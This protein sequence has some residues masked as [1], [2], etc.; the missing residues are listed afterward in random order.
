MNKAKRSP[1]ARVAQ[2]AA[3]AR[4]LREWW[5]SKHRAVT[6]ETA[7]SRAAIC[8]NC[9]LNQDEELFSDLTAAAAGAVKRAFERKFALKLHLPN[10][11]KLKICES[12]GCELKLKI[13]EPLELI[14]DQ[15]TDTQKTALHPDCWILE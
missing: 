2:L 9:P 5:L 14:N 3:G 10:E 15:M 8:I 13:W 6:P 12:C 1:L 11:D 7:A 4:N